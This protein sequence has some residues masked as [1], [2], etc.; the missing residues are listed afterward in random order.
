MKNIIVI[1]VLTFFFSAKAFAV[2][3]YDALNET[4][5]NNTELNAERENINASVEDINISK[6]DY[7]PS[8]TLSGSKSYENTNT[9]KNQDGSGASISDTN[10][11]T[12]SIKL[13]QTLIDKTRDVEY[14]KNIVGLELA[15]A[16]LLKKEQDILYSAIDAFTLV[17]LS[18]DIG[19]LLSILYQLSRQ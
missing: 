17:I 3:L 2:T 18:R 10:P 9:L 15:K 8:V 4:F 11:L 5:R 16:K 14:S 7:M 6:A 12:T 19:S 13:E 1:L